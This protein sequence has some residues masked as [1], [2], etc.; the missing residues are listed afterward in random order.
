[1]VRRVA[2]LLA[3]AVAACG[4][5]V[6]GAYHTPGAGDHDAG[7]PPFPATCQEIAEAAPG[8]AD[9]ERTLYLDHDPAQPWTAYCHD[10]AG[11]PT[12]Y[13]SL[14]ETGPSHNYAQYTAG[15]AVTGTTVRTAYTRLRIDPRTRL[16][17]IADQ[18]FSSSTGALMGQSDVPVRSMP[19]GV[20]ANCG[21]ATGRGNIDLRGT[22][23]AV[24]PDAFAVGGYKAFG[25]ATYAS[26]DQVVELRGGGYCG[27]LMSLPALF[28]PINTNGDFQLSLA[29]LDQD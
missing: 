16:V 10:L 22:R 23:F 19:Y 15:G 7:A 6:S 27:W 5:P 4:D 2:A 20:A 25:D 11:A 1:M 26:G 24:T 9:G 17:N 13:L 18:R 21:G 14:V 28:A 8:A 29:Y 3:F 12:E